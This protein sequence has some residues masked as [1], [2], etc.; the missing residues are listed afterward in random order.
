MERPQPRG[1]SLVD[2]AALEDVRVEEEP[3]SLDQKSSG[4]GSSKSGATIAIPG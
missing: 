1:G 2:R 3:H 4:K